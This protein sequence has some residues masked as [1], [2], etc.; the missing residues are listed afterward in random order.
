MYIEL[1]SCIHSYPVFIYFLKIYLFLLYRMGDMCA[2]TS[3]YHMHAVSSEA[4]RGHLNPL[5]QELQT[6]VSYHVV[7]GTKPQ[8]LGRAVIAVNHGATSPSS[9]F[10]FI[11]WVSGSNCNM[12]LHIHRPSNNYFS[13]R[14]DIF[15]LKALT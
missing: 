14:D 1:L 7:L 4:R 9:A 15:R 8:S 5:E 10:L 3:V 11:D 6:V 13:R 2:C 12:Q